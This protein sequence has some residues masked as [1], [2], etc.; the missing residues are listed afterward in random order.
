MRMEYLTCMSFKRSQVMPWVTWLPSGPTPLSL[1]S[2][3]GSVHIRF[4]VQKCDTDSFFSECF[5]FS[6]SVSFLQSSTLAFV[7]ILPLPEGQTGEAWKPSIQQ[8]SLRNRRGMDRNEV[9]YFLLNHRHCTVEAQVQFRASLYGSYSK[10]SALEQVFLQVL[11]VSCHQF[12]I[13]IIFVL[14][15]L[16]R[17]RGEASGLS[18]I[19]TLFC[20]QG[21][22][23]RKNTYFLLGG[24]LIGLI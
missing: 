4:L 22:M 23:N 5:G 24:A 17:Q 18:E 3:F 9:L 12:S 15:L 1:G 7:Y 13:L 6:P 19:N 14:L 20:N 11:P 8:R 16:E 2:D 10:L 21:T